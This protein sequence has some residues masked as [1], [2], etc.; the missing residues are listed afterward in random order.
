[1]PLEVYVMLQLH[2]LT[3]GSMQSAAQGHANTCSCCLHTATCCTVP[4][5]L[6]SKGADCKPDTPNL[7]LL[8][9]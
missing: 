3:L 1:M 5:L 2:A 8:N 9:K 4:R 6:A 7:F